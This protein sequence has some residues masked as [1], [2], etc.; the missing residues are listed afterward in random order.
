MSGVRSEEAE[1]EEITV[2]KKPKSCKTTQH[3]CGG[4]FCATN[5]NIAKAIAV[6]IIVKVHPKYLGAP[7]QV[8][9]LFGEE[10][11]I[12]YEVRG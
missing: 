9:I 6:G 10:T 4:P 11:E 7:E 5:K 3:T 1:A 8:T 12:R 2:K